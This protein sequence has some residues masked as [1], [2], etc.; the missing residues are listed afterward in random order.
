MSKHKIDL[1]LAVWRTS[2]YSVG[3]GG[4]CVEIAELDCGYRGVR[5]SKDSAGP[6]LMVTPGEWAVFTA[7]VRVDEFG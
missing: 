2:S 1:S 7:A 5:D 6:V 4:D 3:N